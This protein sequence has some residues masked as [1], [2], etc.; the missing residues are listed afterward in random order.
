MSKVQGQFEAAVSMSKVQG[1][2][3]AAV[4]SYAV[5]VSMSS[6]NVKGQSAD[7][8]ALFLVLKCTKKCKNN[9]TCLASIK[10]S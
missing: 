6:C 8:P 7:I 4:S 3:K 10:S 2:F 9:D 1:Q 5:A